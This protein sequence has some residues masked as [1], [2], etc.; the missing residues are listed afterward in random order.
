MPQ[1]RVE[2]RR[3]KA[4]DDQ[5]R[6]ITVIEIKPTSFER[7]INGELIDLS[8]RYTIFELPDGEPVN[9]RKDGTYEVVNTR[10]ILREIG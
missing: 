6:A 4:A 3:F 1:G 7:G 10:Q 2:L 9:R 5:G 8:P